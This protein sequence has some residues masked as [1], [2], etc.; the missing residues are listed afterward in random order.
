RKTIYFAKKLNPDLVMFTVATPYPS[1]NL[2]QMAFEQ[3]FLKGD[4]WRDF[5]LGTQGSRLPY[6]VENAE[7]WIKKAYFSFYFRPQY[8]LR[9]LSKIKSFNDFKKYCDAAVGLLFF[10]MKK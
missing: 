10:S 4:Y 3:G 1:T 8:I 6:F 5:T 7:T 9:R 2:Y